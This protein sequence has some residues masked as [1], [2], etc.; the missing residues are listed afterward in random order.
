MA[1]W[2]ARKGVTMTTSSDLQNKNVQAF[3][4]LIRKH[5]SNGD[6]SIIYGGQHFN[7]FSQHPNVRVPFFNPKTQKMDY[8]T[9]AGAYQINRPTWLMLNAISSFA[10]FGKESQDLAAV[11]LLRRSGALSAIIA[12]DIQG[13]LKAAS[14]TWASLP[15]TDSMQA[16]TSATIAANEYLNFGGSIA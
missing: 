2:A 14:G 5:E 12:G 11:L 1:L 6:Y 9:A 4:A 13:A 7:D 8:S 10:D 15:Y 3:L 16:H